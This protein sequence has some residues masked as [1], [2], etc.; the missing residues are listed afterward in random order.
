VDQERISE[1]ILER[2]SRDGSSIGNI[3][4]L[5]IL[6][7]T[8]PDLADEEYFR[9]RDELVAAGVLATGRGRG[10]SVMLAEPGSPHGECSGNQRPGRSLRQ[11]RATGLSHPLPLERRPPPLR[12]GFPHPPAERKNPD[13]GNQRPGL[14]AEQA[15]AAG[16]ECL[17]GSC[18]SKR[19]IRRVV[20]GRGFRYGQDSGFAGDGLLRELT[21]IYA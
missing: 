9:I 18:Q 10:G 8:W 20:L 7:E 2:V 11:E 4:L 6:R 3:K 5:G 16:A 21:S 15:K 14:T 13:P 12:P 17:G 19:R 1:A